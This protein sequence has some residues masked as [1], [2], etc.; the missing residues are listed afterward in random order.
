MTENEF[1]EYN[2]GLKCGI[3]IMLVFVVF[4]L[5]LFYQG[6]LNT[7]LILATFGL[8]FLIPYWQL[9]RAKRY[10]HFGSDPY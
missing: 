8:L 9:K 4:P 7:L 3:G 5:L 1:K 10:T 6:L 2:K